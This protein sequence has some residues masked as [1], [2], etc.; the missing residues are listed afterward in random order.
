VDLFVEK[1]E[2]RSFTVTIRISRVNWVSMV[3]VVVRVSIRL[4]LI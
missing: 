2:F 1:G 4:W 3:R